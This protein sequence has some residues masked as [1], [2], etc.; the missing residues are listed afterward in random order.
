MLCADSASNALS[1]EQSVHPEAP[2]EIPRED[3][4]DKYWRELASRTP[5]QIDIRSRT[6]S[7]N[8]DGDLERR[9]SKCEW[10]AGS[11]RQRRQLPHSGKDEEE[12][13]RLLAGCHLSVNQQCNLCEDTPSTSIYIC[14]TD[15]TWKKNCSHWEAV[16]WNLI[17]PGKCSPN[18]KTGAN[19]R[20]TLT[21]KNPRPTDTGTYIMGGWV[22]GEAKGRIG[23]FM[24]RDLNAPLISEGL[25]QVQHTQ[26]LPQMTDISEL[27]YEETL[28]NETGFTDLNL[29]L[30]WMKYNVESQ[31]KTNCY[32]CASA[33][34]HL[35]TVPLMVTFTEHTQTLGDIY[36]ICGDMKLRSRLEGIWYGECILAKVIMPLHIVLI[37]HDMPMYS[38]D[39]STSPTEN[40]W[41]FELH[42]FQCSSETIPSRFN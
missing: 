8:R 6:D 19:M 12:D 34:P 1:G 9:H 10:G 30:E 28:A 4:T 3:A 20:L 33:R 36:W 42:R 35:G 5:D 22:R 15:Q 25:M 40:H 29:W 26:A 17:K 7:C 39:N 13:A 41:H 16:G 23:K 2:A 37:Q 18:G 32:V 11:A 38:D 27:T 24:L 31:N 21:I 14:V